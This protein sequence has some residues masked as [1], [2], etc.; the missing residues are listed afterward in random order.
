MSQEECQRD[1]AQQEGNNNRIN[2]TVFATINNN[3]KGQQSSTF[4]PHKKNHLHRMYCN[5]LGH[6]KDKCYKLYGYTPGYTPKPRN[7]RY[8]K[9]PTNQVCVEALGFGSD[10]TNQGSGSLKNFF[11]K[12]TRINMLISRKCSWITFN[13]QS[14]V[15]NHLTT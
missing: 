14:M 10:S 7:Q 11:S 6:T 15:T 4:T 13:L 9:I 5:I 8:A 1:I 2:E 3:N 12:L